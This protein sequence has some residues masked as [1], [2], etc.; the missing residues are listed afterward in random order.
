M[1]ALT[2]AESLAASGAVNNAA[3]V[4]GG[5]VGDT[6]SLRDRSS[7]ILLLLIGALRLVGR[8][9]QVSHPLLQWILVCTTRATPPVVERPQTRRRAECN[10]CRIFRVLWGRYGV[11]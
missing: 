10:A 1:S 8:P 11:S 4:A 9:S 2:A 5:G 6:G 3:S 7:D